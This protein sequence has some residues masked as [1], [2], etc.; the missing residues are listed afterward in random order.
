[1][2]LEGFSSN[3]H[4]RS[5]A[6]RARRTSGNKL[7]GAYYPFIFDIRNTPETKGGSDLSGRN[8]RFGSRFLM[9]PHSSCRKIY[10]GTLVKTKDLV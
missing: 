2:I 1:M 3:L 10:L 6:K 5:V 9:K 8:T 4:P 7:G